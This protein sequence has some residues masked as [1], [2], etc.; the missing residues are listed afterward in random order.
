MIHHATHRRGRP[1]AVRH[2]KRPRPAG[3]ARP[4]RWQRG[5]HKEIKETTPTP[6]MLN[7]SGSNF[8]AVA[9]FEFVSGLTASKFAKVPVLPI[10]QTPGIVLSLIPTLPAFKYIFDQPGLTAGLFVELV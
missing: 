1:A 9:Y 6:Q 7:R 5:H 10:G 8:V 3:R 4:G 2:A